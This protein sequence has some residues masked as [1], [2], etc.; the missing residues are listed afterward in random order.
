MIS[1]AGV[2]VDAAVGGPAPDN[3]FAAGPY[4]LGVESASRCIVG[5]RGCPT[6]VAGIISPAG[7]QIVAVAGPAPDNHLAA[8]PDCCVISSGL[9]RVGEA[10]GCPT[11]GA[12]IVSPAGVKK[13]G[14]REGSLSA[15][16]DH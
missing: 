13:A 11:V 1:S 5:A 14:G 12:G 2:Q 7:V 3:H 9:G 16:D 4:C 15:P 10:G 6:I 8:G